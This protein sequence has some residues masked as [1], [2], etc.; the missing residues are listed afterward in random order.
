MAKKTGCGLRCLIMKLIAILLAGAGLYVIVSGIMRQWAGMFPF[1]H[2]FLWYAGGFL[3]WCLA[4]YFK[5]KACDTCS[6]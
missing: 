3:L 6:L 1:T 2:V 4:K 5:M